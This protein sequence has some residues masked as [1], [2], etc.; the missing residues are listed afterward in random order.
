MCVRCT[1][2]CVCACRWCSSLLEEGSGK[3]AISEQLSLIA[4][5]LFCWAA[6]LCK[7]T[8][9]CILGL[10]LWSFHHNRSSCPDS[11]TF[12]ASPVIIVLSLLVFFSLPLYF[13]SAVVLA[14]Y[15]P[16]PISLPLCFAP[17]VSTFSL[18]STS[19]SLFFPRC[20]FH[21]T[22]LAQCVFF[23]ALS[24]ECC[25]SLPFPYECFML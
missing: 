22:S 21:F 11:E 17:N 6:A 15:L 23:Q 2:A 8:K 1:Q 5:T 10:L 4:S 24:P 18:N 25:F 16:A 12:I 7:M 13:A 3:G 14:Q 19:A 9:W 20:H